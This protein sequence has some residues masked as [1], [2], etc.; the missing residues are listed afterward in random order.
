[1]NPTPSRRDVLA[2][3][4]TLAAAGALSPAARA[5]APHVLTRGNVRPV[6]VASANGNQWKDAEGLTCVAKAFKMITGGADVLDAVV[7]GVMRGLM[8]AFM[9]AKHTRGR[10]RAHAFGR[11]RK[12]RGDMYFSVG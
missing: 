11:V 1:M 10:A 12:R 6:V 2:A 4:A 9:Q 5:Q 8:P 7:A 3:T